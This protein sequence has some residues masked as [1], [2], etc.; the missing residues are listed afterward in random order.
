ME[1]SYRFTK[2][3]KSY[4]VYH[5]VFCTRYRRKVFLIDGVASRFGK[6]LSQI[7]EQN[8]YDVLT[9]ECGADYCYLHVSVLPDV[10]PYNVCKSIKYG[11]GSTL[12][13]EFPQLSSQQV[14]WTR[15]FFA[16]TAEQLSLGEI[17]E[18]VQSQPTRP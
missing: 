7:C 9:F 3:T 5:L 2:T 6:L 4:V 17:Q 10:S 16:S 12:I 18:Y 15:S 8:D 1:G 13:A 14:L 11:T